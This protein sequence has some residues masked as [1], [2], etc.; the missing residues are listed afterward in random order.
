MSS[1]PVTLDSSARTSDSGGV[2][3]P[4]LDVPMFDGNILNWRSFLEQ[5]AISV[6]GR[7]HLSDSEKLVYLRRIS[8]LRE[9]SNAFPA[10]ANVTPKP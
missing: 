10:P 7:A 1:I 2:R 8:L 5:F 4:K 3:F 9:S 6:H